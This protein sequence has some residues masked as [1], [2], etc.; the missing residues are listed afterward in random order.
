MVVLSMLTQ[1]QLERQ[2]FV[3]NAIFALLED[4]Q[5]SNAELIWDI[6]MIGEIRDTIQHWLEAKNLTQPEEFYPSVQV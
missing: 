6:E 2:D 3:D 4:L 5:T 1:A